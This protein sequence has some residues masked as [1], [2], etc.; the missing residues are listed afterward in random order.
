MSHRA[1][2]TRTWDKQYKET[3]KFA[4]MLIK[5]PVT[6]STRGIHL[7]VLLIF[8]L[9]TKPEKNKTDPTPKDPAQFGCLLLF[10]STVNNTGQML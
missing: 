7:P 4:S 1:C 8:S 2:D 10:S 9:T 6:E 5:L 3:I